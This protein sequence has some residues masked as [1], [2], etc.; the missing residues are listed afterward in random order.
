MSQVRNA[1]AE[2]AD[3]TLVE[4]R[5]VNAVA[6]AAFIVSLGSFLAVTDKFF[7]FIPIVA[8]I[9][10]LVGFAVF[11]GSSR[12]LIGRRL[13]A[14][15][16]CIGLFHATWIVGYE[17]LRRWFITSHAQPVVE[18]WIEYLRRGE[19]YQA[20]QL[21]QEYFK[22]E[23]AGVDLHA[24]YNN[25]EFEPGMTENEKQLFKDSSP[26]AR[27]KEFTTQE[28]LKTIIL[29][30]PQAEFE[31]VRTEAYRRRKSDDIVADVFRMNYQR[32]G[33]PLS[34]E[35]RVILIRQDLGEYFQA[36]WYVGR[37]TF[38]TEPLTF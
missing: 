8:V 5:P 25:L 14:V 28:P 16:L 21:T 26:G 31:F 24:H 17:G 1:F 34:L 27:F 6:V 7:L 19:L 4:Y 20:H 36:H 29:E 22:R 35:F 18:E 13:C 32:E 33:Q 10:A 15:A 2:E 11:A 38:T 37:V 3:D 30:A 9:L 12:S 23:L